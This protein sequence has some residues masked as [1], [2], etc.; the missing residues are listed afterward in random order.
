MP[1]I[2]KWDERLGAL[3]VCVSVS[4]VFRQNWVLEGSFSLCLLDRCIPLLRKNGWALYQTTPGPQ[5]SLAPWLKV[6]VR[7]VKSLQ[8]NAEAK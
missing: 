2:I 5:G 4:I 7:T 3:A 1:F 8:L 6:F